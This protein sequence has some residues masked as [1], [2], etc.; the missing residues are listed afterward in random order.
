MA[1]YRFR[2]GGKT[3]G[4]YL[5]AGGGG[6]Y[7][8]V[9]FSQRVAVG[10]SVTCSPEWLWWGFGC[11]SGVVTN[12]Q[13]VASSSSTAPSNHSSSSDRVRLAVDDSGPGIPLEERPRIF[14]RF[15]R[16]TNQPGGAGLGLAIADA[17]VR[18]TGGRW[19]VGTSAQGG[20]SMAVSW[21]RALAASARR[22]SRV[23]RVGDRP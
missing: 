11:S 2:Y 16:A 14:D 1:N 22:S 13:T 17:V 3:F 18:N 9:S 6:F 4:A 21:P 20:A 10:N 7:R 12:N 15:Q 8:N 23:T 19:D 5:I